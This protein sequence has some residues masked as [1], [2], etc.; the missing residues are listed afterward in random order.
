MTIWAHATRVHGFVDTYVG[1]QRL[2]VACALWLRH[3]HLS[4]TWIGD[5]MSLIRSALAGPLGVAGMT[6]SNLR[7]LRE[8][9]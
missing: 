3:E 2:Q 5:S 8:S 9:E 1:G 4:V 6:V 7:L